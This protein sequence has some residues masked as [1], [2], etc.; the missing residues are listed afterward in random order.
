MGKL[1][2]ATVKSKNEPG[3]YGDGD[4]LFL[5]VKPTGGRSWVVRVQKNGR[6]RDFGLG[7]EGKVTLAQAR[8]KA[9]AVRSQM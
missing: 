6:R 9:A 5:I 4:G 8:I 3:R 1:S 2:A 7:S